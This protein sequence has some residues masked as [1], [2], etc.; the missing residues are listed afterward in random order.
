MA[1]KTRKNKDHFKRLTN[2]SSKNED[3]KRRIIFQ[4]DVKNKSKNQKQG[5]ATKHTF[6]LR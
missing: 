1:I 5:D 2:D 3:G 4:R 6:N